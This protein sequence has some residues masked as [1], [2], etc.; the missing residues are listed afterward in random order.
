VRL[1]SRVIAIVAT[2]GILILDTGGSDVTVVVARR[3][4]VASDSAA[5]ASLPFES[6]TDPPGSGL[7]W[8]GPNCAGEESVT[9]LPPATVWIAGR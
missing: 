2:V 8:L 9:G 4:H 7:R 5:Q 3:L 6:E 1:V